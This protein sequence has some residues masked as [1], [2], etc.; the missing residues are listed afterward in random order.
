MRRGGHRAREATSWWTNRRAGQNGDGVERNGAS[1]RQPCGRR[2]RPPCGET[3][4]DAEQHYE[5]RRQHGD[6]VSR[7]R[8]IDIPAQDF[9]GASRK[10]MLGVTAINDC[11]YCAWGHSHWAMSQGIPLNEVNQVLSSQDGSTQGERSRRSG[12]HS[13]DST[14]PQHLD[15]RSG[16]AE[17]PSQPL[18]S[19]GGPGDRRVRVLHYVHR[20][21]AATRWTFYSSDYAARVA[22]SPSLRPSWGSRARPDPARPGLAGEAG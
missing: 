17:E 18:Q 9:Q 16:L 8:P 1:R 4:A 7:H 10:V 6:Y 22:P 13:L 2:K 20:I 19:G 21:S 15:D 11:R 3:D 12:G 5:N 14:M